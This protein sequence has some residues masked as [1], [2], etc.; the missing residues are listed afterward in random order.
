M[1]FSSGAVLVS[2]SGNCFPYK[3]G[4]SF[5]GMQYS[6]WNEPVFPPSAD[7]P[8]P[9]TYSVVGG[10]QACGASTPLQYVVGMEAVC[11]EGSVG[12]GCYV[13]CPITICRQPSR[14]YRKITVPLRA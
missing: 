4:H 7:V 8:V 5:L 13:P 12:K 6:G 2:L 11:G 9:V 10:H 3:F 14:I 1:A